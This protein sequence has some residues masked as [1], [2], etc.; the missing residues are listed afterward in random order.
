MQMQS[1]TQEG[2]VILARIVGRSGRHARISGGALF[3][4]VVAC[5]MAAG[6]ALALFAAGL[7]RLQWEGLVT[8]AGG[9]ALYAL[10]AMVVARSPARRWSMA[11][12]GALR[13]RL[14]TITY[15]GML[16]RPVRARGQLAWLTEEG[17]LGHDFTA[18]RW[19]E[20]AAY[21]LDEDLSGFLRLELDPSKDRTRAETI[22]SWTAAV[23][24]LAG[25][26]LPLVAGIAL[27]ASDPLRLD[28][29]GALVAGGA[30]TALWSAA[31]LLELR[32]RIPWTA[33]EDGDGRLR[34]LIDPEQF[35]FDEVKDLL[36]A[37]LPRT[38]SG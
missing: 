2:R 7:M 33:S 36:R 1:T 26:L 9:V 35:P 17:L 30:L 22:R 3:L 37:H 19:E 29:L 27:L 8:A 15:A 12:A 10:A 31:A 23:L 25:S 32:S 38:T 16:G 21:R 5:C 20:F 4:G 24:T 6:G 13:A 14:K 34:L 18:Y 11:S 28:G